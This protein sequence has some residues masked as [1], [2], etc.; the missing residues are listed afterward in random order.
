MLQQLLYYLVYENCDIE[1]H[2]ELSRAQLEKITNQGVV[3]PV[4]PGLTR[5]GLAST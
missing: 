3:A 1:L 5:P 2:R 4:G